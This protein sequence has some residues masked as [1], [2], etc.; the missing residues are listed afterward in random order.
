[1]R[2][3]LRLVIG[4][5]FAITCFALFL[6]LMFV[7][8]YLV[9]RLVIRTVRLMASVWGWSELVYD[10]AYDVLF[11]LVFFLAFLIQLVVC[12]FYYRLF[13]RIDRKL[14]S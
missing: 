2:P 3:A 5:F 7:N 12:Y 4:L 11:L 1:M 6:V 8:L 9:E 14:R 13:A 10:A